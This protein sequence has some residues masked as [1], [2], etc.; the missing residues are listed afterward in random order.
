MAISVPIV[1]DWDPTG[2]KKATKDF[3]KLEKTTDKAAFAVKK[4]FVPATA[5]IAGLTAAAGLA[6]K[7]AV[8][9][10]K[11]QEE[12]ARQLEVTTGA[13]EEQVAAVEKY[14]ANT[15]MAAAVSDSELRPAF[16]NLVRA[17]GDVTE[18]QELMNLALDI[19]AATGKDLETVSAALQE[20]YKGEVGPLKELD[21]SLAGM[22]KS[23]ASAEEVMTELADTFGG[24]AQE[25]ANTLAGRFER[26]QLQI[27]NA[28]EAIGYALLPVVENLVPVLEKVATLIGDNTDLFIIIGGAIG[29]TAAAIV[30]LNI[31][32][33]AWNAV[34]AI[35]TT[36]NGV[37]STSFT[38]LQVASG[39][40]VFTALV[41]IFIALQKRFD[42]IGK[43]VAGLSKLFG[44]LKDAVFA[45]VNFLIDGINALIDFANKLP[46][47]E[48]DKIN[49]KLGETEDA[50]DGVTDATEEMN[51]MW[52]QTDEHAA[53]V[54]QQTEVAR[55]EMDAMTV[56][57][58]DLDLVTR[59][60][61]EELA[62]EAA[63]HEALMESIKK[64][65]EE[66]Y[67]LN[68][69]MQRLFDQF[70][71]EE[72]M[73][74]FKDAIQNVTDTIAEFGEDSREAE[75]AQRD[76]RRELGNLIE[77]FDNIPSQVQTQLLVELDQGDYDAVV[78]KLSIMQALADT[79]NLAV[80]DAR[81]A[82]ETHTLG[83]MLNVATGASNVT[84]STPGLVGSVNIGAGART[85]M[86]PQAV[87]INMPTGANGEDVV[88]ALKDHARRTGGLDIPI[89]GAVRS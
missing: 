37:L 11:Q 54:A 40:I 42:I 16:A 72:A 8:Q 2:L 71:N 43:I 26:M 14:I 36:I 17:T 15:E 39:I 49:F 86:A 7:A 30:A 5:A 51:K 4:A 61:N 22:I 25:G 59:E 56:S 62:R 58:E 52:V 47:V 65:N 48:I 1:S 21:K 53:M 23:G 76:L 6:V 29:T 66:V 3:K 75:Q 38:A 55:L 24:A 10:Q 27:A 67:G 35:T 79:A 84:A 80:D 74:D 13:T 78:S 18:A 88:R 68:E 85:S 41:A 82:M 31:A 70:D 81:K 9:D 46:F 73:L 57:S 28:Q 87:T 32:M 83:A 50:A 77:E 12:L 33:K 89:S 63:E 64:H 69:E 45:F 34:G 19:S 20:A 60:L 44:V